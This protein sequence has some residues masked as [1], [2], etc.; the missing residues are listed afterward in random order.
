MSAFDSPED[1]DFQCPRDKTE[2]DFPQEIEPNIF[3]MGASFGRAMAKESAA[4]IKGKPKV[5][6]EESKRRLSVCGDCQFFVDEKRCAKC[7]CFVGFKARLRS[8]TCPIGKW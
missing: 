5:S 6:T 2:E 4:R 8:G 1:E 7:G 3:A